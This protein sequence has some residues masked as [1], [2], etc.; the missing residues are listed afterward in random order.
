MTLFVES[1]LLQSPGSYFSFQDVIEVTSDLTGLK[2]H[3]ILTSVME[4]DEMT[5]NPLKCKNTQNVPDALN[6]HNHKA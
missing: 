5:L 1:V 2:S 3:F 6:G 4:G